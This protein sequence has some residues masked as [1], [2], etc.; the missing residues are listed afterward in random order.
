[1]VFKEDAVKM[2]IYMSKIIQKE[3]NKYC[4]LMYIYGI[5]KNGVD[6]P[7]CSANRCRCKEWT[8]GDSG[9]ETGWDE[10]RKQD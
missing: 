1:M 6:E 3:K 10:Q 5:Q 7:I 2:Y 8:R 4:I 9:R